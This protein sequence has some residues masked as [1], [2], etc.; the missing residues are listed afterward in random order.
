MAQ[1][2]VIFAVVGYNQFEDM[3]SIV[4][5]KAVFIDVKSKFDKTGLIEGGFSFWRL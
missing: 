5:K 2:D 3:S 1:A 4:N